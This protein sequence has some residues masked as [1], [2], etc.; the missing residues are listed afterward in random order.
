MDSKKCSS[1]GLLKSLSDFYQRK[2]HRRGEY[3]E[4][5]KEC[6]KER[7]RS[8]YHH[9]HERQLYLAK[10][11]KKRYIQERENWLN[12]I[13]DQP[14]ADCGIKYPPFVMDFDHKDGYAKIGSVSWLAKHNTSSFEKIKKEIEKCDLVCANC[15]RIRTH[16]RILKVKTA[17]VANVVK[18]LV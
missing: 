14:C 13:K 4:R 15:H 8:Y 7:G 11:R 1:C 12:F 3:Y 2:K 10:L 9:N 17:T 6:F 18:A 16:A 5:C